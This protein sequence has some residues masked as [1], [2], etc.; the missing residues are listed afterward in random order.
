[1][2]LYK[3][4]TDIPAMIYF[5]DLLLHSISLLLNFGSYAR[6]NVELRCCSFILRLLSQT[7]IVPLLFTMF[8]LS[9]LL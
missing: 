6:I 4:E 2:N 9:L 7:D 5:D 1:M 8:S 3:I